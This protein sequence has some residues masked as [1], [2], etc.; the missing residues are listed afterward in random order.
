MRGQL[1]SR[2]EN[3]KVM[4]RYLYLYL[5]YTYEIKIISKCTALGVNWPADNTCIAMFSFYQ[6]W[7]EECTLVELKLDLGRDHHHKATDHDSMPLLCTHK[8][9]AFREFFATCCVSV[10]Y[11]KNCLK[12]IGCDLIAQKHPSHIIYSIYKYRLHVEYH[13]YYINDLIILSQM[14]MICM[15]RGGNPLDWYLWVV[16]CKFIRRGRR[17]WKRWQTWCDRLV[18]QGEISG[19]QI[20]N[21]IDGIA[22]TAIINKLNI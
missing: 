1:V 13:K 16:F 12:R 11:A 3:W 18:V 4:V 5:Y 17:E 15:S 9:L 6:V 19:R 21:R 2:L 10:T 7:L 14:K 8:N 22:D 20:W